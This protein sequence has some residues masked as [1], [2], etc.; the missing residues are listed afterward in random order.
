ML[1]PFINRLLHWFVTGVS[2][3][4]LSLMMLSKG[5]S[6]ETLGLVMAIASLFVVVFEFPSGILSD[7]VG[8]KKVYLFS[9]TISIVVTP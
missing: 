1:V 3:T 7:M 4:V 9:L 6:L 5:C 8:Q 2:T